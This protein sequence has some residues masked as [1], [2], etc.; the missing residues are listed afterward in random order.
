[1]PPAENSR[2]H[3]PRDAAWHGKTPRNSTENLEPGLLTKKA[4]HTLIICGLEAYRD[5]DPSEV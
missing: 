4:V 2:S 3:Q 5:K 1:M